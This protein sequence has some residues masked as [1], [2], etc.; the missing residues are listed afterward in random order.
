MFDVEL[1]ATIRRSANGADDGKEVSLTNRSTGSWPI[2]WTI[3]SDQR[4]VYVD[5]NDCIN[6]YV[7]EGTKTSSGSLRYKSIR[8]QLGAG[9]ALLVV[10]VS[11]FSYA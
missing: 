5:R 10:M 1:V 8:R 9:I 6:D 3:R 7:P 11:I 2:G 4:T